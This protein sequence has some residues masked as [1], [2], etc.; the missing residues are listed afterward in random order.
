MYAV[1]ITVRVAHE[2]DIETVR[3]ASIAAV[4]PSRAEDGCLFFDLLFDASDPC[5]VRFY[6]AYVDRAAFDVHANAP[7]TR[8]WGRICLPLLD[9]STIRVP[10]AVSFEALGMTSSQ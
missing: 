8:E 3:A 7:H 9:R 6:E 2:A 4:P 1:T 10:E 5:L